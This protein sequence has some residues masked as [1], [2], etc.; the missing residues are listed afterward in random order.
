MLMSFMGCF[1]LPVYSFFL[2]AGVAIYGT[3]QGLVHLSFLVR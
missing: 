3:K 2:V 1:F